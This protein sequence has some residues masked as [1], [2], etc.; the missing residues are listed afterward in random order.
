MKIL[1]LS[2]REMQ[3]L[4]ERYYANKRHVQE[5]VRKIVDDVRN[6]GDKAVLKYTKRFDKV[7]FASKDLKVSANEINGSFQNI[8]AAFITSLK[9]IIENIQRYYKKELPKSWKIKYDDGAELGEI[10]RPVESVGIYVPAGTAPLVSSVY[11][12]VVPAKMAGVKK[13]IM[14]TPP[15]KYGKRRFAH[16][17]CSEPFKSGRDL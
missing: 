3:K 14:A 8:D 5:K 4:F 6:E 9:N 15:N 17:G 1:K 10:F 11:M 16:T 13:I 2:S 7:K 12:S